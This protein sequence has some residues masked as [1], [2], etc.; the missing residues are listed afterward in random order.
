MKAKTSEEFIFS[1]RGAGAQPTRIS[2]GNCELG[3]IQRERLVRRLSFR[4]FYHH[5]LSSK[6]SKLCSRIEERRFST[7]I[8]HRVSLYISRRLTERLSSLWDLEST[9]I[10][11]MQSD[12]GRLFTRIVRDKNKISVA[13]VRKSTILNWQSQAVANI[14]IFSAD[15][16][17]LRSVGPLKIRQS[18]F[19]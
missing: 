14:R 1:F 11:R 9:V 5:F 7:T 4:P 18:C 13:W 2:V 6:Q 10:M 3:Q 15:N 19:A 12:F 16:C 17:Q 8:N